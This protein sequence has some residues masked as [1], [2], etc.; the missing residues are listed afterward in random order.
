MK[1]QVILRSFS[2]DFHAWF[3]T[4]FL[5]FEKSD[6]ECSEEAQAKLVLCKEDLDDL[7]T[8]S[9]NKRDQFVVA[10]FFQKI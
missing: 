9:G 7:Q 10:L 1:Q 6:D 3:N 2:F 8:T 5:K 4:F